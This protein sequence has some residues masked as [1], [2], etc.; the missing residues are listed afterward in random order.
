MFV[1]AGKARFWVVEKG[2]ARR[3]CSSIS[4]SATGVCSSR[5][6][7]RV[8]TLVVIAK[9]DR[10]EVSDS[11]REAARRIPGAR[12]VELDS[13]HYLTLREPELVT[14]LIRDFLTEARAH[15]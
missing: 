8:P 10:P 12:L 3:C 7:T 2:E 4:G 14:G 15:G 5:S 9:H 11:G 6:W 13:D 1:G